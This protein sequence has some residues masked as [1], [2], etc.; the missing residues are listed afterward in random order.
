MEKE[1]VIKQNDTEQLPE[2]ITR[3]MI[4]AAKQKYGNDKVK[5]I[6]I[7]KE[8]SDEVDK[9][10]LAAVPSRFVIAQFMQNADKDAKKSHEILVKNCLL[11]HKEEVMADDALFMGAVNGI[12]ELI[13]IR[14]TVIKNC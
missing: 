12:A 11:S 13:P 4:D 2:G 3:V 1:T 10:V 8:N 5:L 14:K 7:L 6:D 9:T